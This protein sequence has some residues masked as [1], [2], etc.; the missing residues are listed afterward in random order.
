MRNSDKK[1]EMTLKEVFTSIQDWLKYFKSK[2]LIILII[3]II[4]FLLGFLY[5]YRKPPLYVAKNTFVLDENNGSNG[6]S[7]LSALGLDVG[8]EDARGLFNSSKNIL[9]LYQSNL[10]LSEVLLTPVSTDNT[11]KDLLLNLFL[12]ESGL[13]KVYKGNIFKVGDSLNNLSLEQ[14]AVIKEVVEY[15]KAPNYMKVEE[16]PKSNGIITVTV[17]SKDEKFS[18]LFCD[19]LVEIVNSYYIETQTQKISNE[20]QVLEQKTNYTRAL[21]NNQSV[22]AATSVDNVPYANPNKTILRVPPQR[23]QIDIEANRA[24]YVELVKNLEMKQMLL[25]QETPLIKQ[26]DVPS[27]PLSVVTKPKIFYGIVFAI[28]FGLL[29]IGFLFVRRLYKKTMNS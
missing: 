14:N 29:T 24:I 8:G 26:I 13:N 2:I 3:A 22:E 16:M 9:W 21:L 20:I 19:V 15:V 5:A 12:K 11:H 25:A 17:S 10:M 23:K 4:G 18:K 27:Y 1:E 7:G 28:V 6:L